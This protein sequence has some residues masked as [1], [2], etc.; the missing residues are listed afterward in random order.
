MEFLRINWN[1]ISSWWFWPEWCEYPA[2]EAGALHHSAKYTHD[3]EE[4][5]GEFR[6]GRV[7]ASLAGILC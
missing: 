2:G 6:E 7:I 1:P 4:G 5:E 3:P